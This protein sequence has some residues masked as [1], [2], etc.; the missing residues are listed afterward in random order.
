LRD[1]ATIRRWKV[2]RIVEWLLG[3]VALGVA[4]LAINFLLLILKVG[5]LKT[6]LFIRKLTSA[7]GELPG[8][9]LL[10]CTTGEVSAITFDMSQSRERI[11]PVYS[12]ILTWTG[13]PR[14]VSKVLARGR[15]QLTA[16]S[17]IF[18]A[19][20]LPLLVFG[21]WITLFV[22]WAGISIIALLVLHQFVPFYIWEYPTFSSLLHGD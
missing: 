21:A 15:R 16:R 3:V 7:L 9:V 22:S 13:A 8:E 4:S 1:Q 17:M 2:N 6:I 5:N 19:I 11:I 12:G 20:F 10:S 18:I 14:P